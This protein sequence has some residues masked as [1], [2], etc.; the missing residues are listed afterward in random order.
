MNDPVS[1]VHSVSGSNKGLGCD[2]AA[3]RSLRCSCMASAC[4]DVTV[5]LLKS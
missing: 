3:K 2:L 4:E 1:V 5:D